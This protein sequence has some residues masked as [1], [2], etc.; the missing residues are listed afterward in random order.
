MTSTPSVDAF[1][2]RASKPEEGLLNQKPSVTAGS[3]PPSSG[4]TCN[5]NAPKCGASTQ[6]PKSLGTSGEDSTGSARDSAPYWSEFTGGIS[7]LLW[8]PTGTGSPGSDLNS[9]RGW[10]SKTAGR[11]WFSTSRMPAPNPSLPKIYSPSSIRSAAGCTDS[12]ATGPQ[13][14]RI[15]VYP[16]QVQKRAIASWLD[17][18]RWTH[19]LSV[20]LLRAGA[21]AAWRTVAK[22]V[23]SELDSHRPEG[24]SVPYQIKR[25]IKRTSVR[26]AWGAL[27]AFN[28][29]GPRCACRLDEDFAGSASL[30]H[31]AGDTRKA[32]EP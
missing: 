3:A 1:L 23:M 17:A 9:S 12:A 5:G 21:P 8:L 20:E 2:G 29:T 4:E 26:D 13:S 15:Q 30:S 14:R 6:T 24:R 11:S 10:S 18:S 7:S 16:N 25:Q 32:N 19:N 31:P 22:T 27:K 28:A